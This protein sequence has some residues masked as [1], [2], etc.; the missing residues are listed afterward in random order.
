MKYRIDVLYRTEAMKKVQ[1]Y[2]DKMMPDKTL[3]ARQTFE[4]DT[5]EPLTDEQLRKIEDCCPDWAD[6]I[7]VYPV[8]N[9]VV[10]I[11]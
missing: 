2:L 10:K 3:S 8:T 9:P 11:H 7:K 1:V 6:G 4:F 5:K